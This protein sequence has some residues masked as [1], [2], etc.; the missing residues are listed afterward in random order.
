MTHL[1]NAAASYVKDIG[2]GMLSIPTFENTSKQKMIQC[3]LQTV[4]F[5]PTQPWRA[6]V[7][8]CLQCTLELLRRAGMS[9]P[10][11]VGHDAA[12]VF[13]VGTPLPW[14]RRIRLECAD[15]VPTAAWEQLRAAKTD[16]VMDTY[17]DGSALVV[18]IT[19]PNAH[20]VRVQCRV[21]KNREILQSHVHWK[22]ACCDVDCSRRSPWVPVTRVGAVDGIGPVR[23]FISAG[24][25][26]RHLNLVSADGADAHV[27]QQA[28][29][30]VTPHDWSWNGYSG[31]WEPCVPIARPSMSLFLP[32]MVVAVLF[33]V[34]FLVLFGID[35]YRCGKKQKRRTP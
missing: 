16:F 33:I 19:Q 15:A 17:V 22:D 11:L 24:D 23:V 31:V 20:T 21:E 12:A 1:G 6:D 4:P 13:V 35:H 25:I 8:D 7:R 34:L 30:R 27:V 10:V 29:E 9:P 28:L 14:Q 32:G 26:V 3:K 5:A 18:R 2:E